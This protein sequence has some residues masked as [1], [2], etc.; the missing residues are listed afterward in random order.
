MALGDSELELMVMFTAPP[1]EH[2][3]PSW[4]TEISAPDVPAPARSTAPPALMV[5]VAPLL[6]ATA[7]PVIRPPVSMVRPPAM[8]RMS[9]LPGPVF[10][11][12]LGP[13]M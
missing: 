9:L 12:P 7:S 8:L 3:P 13:R 4:S 6:P 11:A 5:I 1:P 10:S 2:D